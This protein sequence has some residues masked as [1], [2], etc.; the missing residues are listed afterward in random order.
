MTEHFLKV[1]KFAF[2]AVRDPILFRFDYGKGEALDSRI[3]RAVFQS[4]ERLTYAD[5]KYFLVF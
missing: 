2:I 3:I 1:L 5:D 4:T